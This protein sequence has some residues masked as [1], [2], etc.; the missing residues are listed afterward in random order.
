MVI[1]HAITLDGPL[2]ECEE[3]GIT[4]VCDLKWTGD[5]CHPQKRMDG[6]LTCETL[7]VAQSHTGDYHDNMNSEMFMKWLQENLYS[8]FAKKYPGEKMILITDN[9]P[10]HHA[11]EIGSLSNCSKK[12][13]DRINGYTQC[14]LY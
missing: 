3:D 7:W 5:T 14:R 8:L 12:T 9:V 11:R 4:P 1:L 13:T 6:K 2:Y 10:Y